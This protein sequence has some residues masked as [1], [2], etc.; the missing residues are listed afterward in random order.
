MKYPMV[1]VEWVDSA[2][3]AGWHRIEHTPDYHD[4]LE[5]QSAGFLIHKDQKSI[6]LALQLTNSG[7]VGELMTIP[8]QCVRRMVK[9]KV[10]PSS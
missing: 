6:T 4:P 3:M 8:R 9:V 7:Q 10:P 1:Y 2:G 5:C